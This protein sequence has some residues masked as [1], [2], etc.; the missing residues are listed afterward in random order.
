VIQRADQGGFD[1]LDPKWCGGRLVAV[2]AATR[3]QI[4]AMAKADPP[5]LGLPL[6]TWSLPK[7]TAHLARERICRMSRETLRRILRGAGVSWQKTKTWKASNDPQFVAK[8]LRIRD[9][10]D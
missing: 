2:V 9:L 10:Y 5:S 7:L 4:L 1:G 3:R 6:A 8:M